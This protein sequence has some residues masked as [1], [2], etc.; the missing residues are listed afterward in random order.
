M[1]PGNDPQKVDSLPHDLIFE[2]LSWLPVES[3]LRFKTVCKFWRDTIQEHYF[4]NLN[5]RRRSLID[6]DIMWE[7]YERDSGDDTKF[8]TAGSSCNGILLERCRLTNKYRVRNP[9]TNH[10]LQLPSTNHTGPAKILLTRF[11]VRTQE[12]KMVS[13]H[14][15]KTT[16]RSGFEVLTIGTDSTWRPLDGPTNLHFVDHEVA[17]RLYDDVFYVRGWSIA[18][19]QIVICLD[20]VTE[21]SKEVAAPLCLFPAWRN[22]RVSEWRGKFSMA[23]MVEKQIHACVLEDYKKSKWGVQKIVIAELFLKDHPQLIEYEIVGLVGNKLR[24][25]DR[26]RK[27]YWEYDINTGNFRCKYSAPASAN[28]R[29][30]GY[31]PSMVYFRGMQPE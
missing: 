12:Y 1:T 29:F 31:T 3:L 25:I 30:V 22:A 7:E 27:M 18:G 6:I 5:M 26:W 8:F 19:D 17:G 23:T 24:V 28:K 4:T 13:Y 21:Q 15:D 14:W 11:V 10:V 16:K 2:I 20:M 9:L